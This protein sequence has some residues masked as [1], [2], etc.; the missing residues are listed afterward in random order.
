MNYKLNSKV[1]FKKV[2]PTEVNILSVDDDNFIYKIDKIAAYTFLL[3][4]EEK[5]SEEEVNKKIVDTTGKNEVDVKKFLEA[6]YDKMLE[7]NFFVKG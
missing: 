7:L 4:I 3:V 5:L 6:F 2:A 1:F